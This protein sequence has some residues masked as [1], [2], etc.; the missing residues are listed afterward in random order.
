MT[1]TVPITIRLNGDD[2][3]VAAGTTVAQLVEQLAIGGG[4]VAVEVNRAIVPKAAHAQH[5]LVGDDEVE[6]VTIVGGG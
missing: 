6:V 5:V 2:H 4:A 1:T 3:E